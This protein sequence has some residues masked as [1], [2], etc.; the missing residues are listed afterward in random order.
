MIKNETLA[1]EID[2]PQKIGE[3]SKVEKHMLSC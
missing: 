2:K 1:N 3:A